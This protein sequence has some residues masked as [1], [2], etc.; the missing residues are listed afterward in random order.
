MTIP[1]GI[2]SFGTAPAPSY[3]EVQDDVLRLE[4]RPFALIR[5]F[6]IS[7]VVLSVQKGFYSIGGTTLRHRYEIRY[8]YFLPR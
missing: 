2:N 6:V 7:V 1:G 3:S 8:A 5:C 4:E